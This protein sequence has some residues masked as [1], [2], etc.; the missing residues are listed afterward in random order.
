MKL[1]E[2]LL[3]NLGL[4]SK[5]SVLALMRCLGVKG[6]VNRDHVQ[7]WSEIRNSMMHGEMV[8]PW[9]SE[10]GDANMQEL[11]VHDL[12]VP[13]SPSDPDP[14]TSMDGSFR[15]NRIER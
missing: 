15:D 7:T 5:R 8:E 11:L 4:V 12:T 6:N 10:E 1:R 14:T 3:N 13:A 9:L 2:R